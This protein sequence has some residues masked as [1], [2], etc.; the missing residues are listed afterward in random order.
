MNVNKISFPLVQHGQLLLRRL[1]V[2]LP[3]GLRG[4]E[5]S[6]RERDVTVN[7]HC[8]AGLRDELH[9]FQMEYEVCFL[10]FDPAFRSQT[11]ELKI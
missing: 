8:L 6:R 2:N 1:A 5:L 3:D 11:P 4:A 10:S 9:T 7:S